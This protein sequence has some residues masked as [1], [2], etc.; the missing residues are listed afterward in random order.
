MREPLVERVLAK[1]HGAARQPER[2]DHATTAPAKNRFARHAK[3]VGDLAGGK[4]AG[5]HHRRVLERLGLVADDLAGGRQ[6]RLEPDVASRPTS[7]R[8]L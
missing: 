7:L 5:G 3:L 1:P 6:D 4:E 8:F 2:W